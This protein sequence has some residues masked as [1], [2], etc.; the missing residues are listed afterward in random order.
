MLTC[1]EVSSAYCPI[2][3]ANIRHDGKVV[4]VRLATS[5]SSVKVKNA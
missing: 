1:P 2:G 4:N 5:S 3:M